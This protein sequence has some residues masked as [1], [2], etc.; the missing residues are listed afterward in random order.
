[1]NL[2]IRTSEQAQ[3]LSPVDYIRWRSE[4]VTEIALHLAQKFTEEELGWVIDG[5][6]TMRVIR[7]GYPSI[8]PRIYD[9]GEEVSLQDRVFD[10]MADHLR[11]IFLQVELVHMDGVYE[12]IFQAART[13]CRTF[14]NKIE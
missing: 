11:G 10:D 1:M 8:A 13:Y 3:Q 12:E 6:N 2:H 5:R 7:D 4:V 9:D 14:P